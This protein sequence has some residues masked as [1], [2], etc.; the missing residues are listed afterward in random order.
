ML[1]ISA[2]TYI[3]NCVY[4]IIDEDKKYGEE[5]R[6][7]KLGVRN[8]HYLIDK[9]IKDRFE[10]RNPTKEQISKYKKHGCF[11]FTFH[12]QHIFSL[13]LASRLIYT[14]SRTIFFDSKSKFC[15][16][17]YVLSS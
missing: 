5:M 6:V 1:R 3:R 9:K 2:E 10:T 14:C 15:C 16:E 11:I 17:L 13:S 4:K 12:F 7:C 8:I